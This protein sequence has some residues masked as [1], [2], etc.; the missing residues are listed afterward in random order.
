[1]TGVVSR[2]SIPAAVGQNRKRIRILEATVPEAATGG[3]DLGYAYD[4]LYSQE[5]VVDP[6][7]ISGDAI[8]YVC[9]MGTPESP[10]TPP[11]NSLVVG[12]CAYFVNDSAAVASSIQEL[13]IVPTWWPVPY[14]SSGVCVGGFWGVVG[15]GR[16]SRPHA[17]DNPAYTDTG[18]S[19]PFDLVANSWD[20]RI[21]MMY[22]GQYAYGGDTGAG[23]E[24][25]N[26]PW[27]WQDNDVIAA[28]WHFFTTDCAD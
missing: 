14:D 13:R 12:N 5:T 6:A 27:V 1:M 19:V 7:I 28:H 21:A 23:A 15:H 26:V 16:I 9:G 11:E 25:T 4:A 17:S 2:S 8:A 20:L 18:P 22:D 10:T 24:Y 3:C